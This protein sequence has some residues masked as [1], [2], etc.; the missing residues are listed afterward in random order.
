M[1]RADFAYDLPPELIAQAPLAI[2]SASR[3][4]CLDGDSGAL[5]DATVADLPGR[6]RAFQ[7]TILPKLPLPDACLRAVYAVV[8]A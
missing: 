8:A 7:C 4:L 2:R 5:D 1:R 6:L 3:M